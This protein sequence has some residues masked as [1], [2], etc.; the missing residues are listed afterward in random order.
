MQAK[1]SFW[2]K[3]DLLDNTSKYTN[4]RYKKLPKE[5]HEKNRNL[6]ITLHQINI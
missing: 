5:E 2:I 6:C 3:S 4:N 1:P